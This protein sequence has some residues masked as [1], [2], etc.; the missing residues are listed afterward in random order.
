MGKLSALLFCPCY[1]LPLYSA[2]FWTDIF[3]YISYLIAVVSH[4]VKGGLPV[5]ALKLYL[6]FY[7]WFYRVPLL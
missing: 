6:C 4:S 7:G 2:V 3:L 5:F 1:K